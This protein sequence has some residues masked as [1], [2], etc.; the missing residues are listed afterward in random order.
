LEYVEAQP[1]RAV[2]CIPADEGTKVVKVFFI[3]WDEEPEMKDRKG[4]PK[5]G[6][7]PD[8]I[9]LVNPKPRGAMRFRTKL[10]TFDRPRK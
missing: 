4:S 3:S 5:P 1:G 7:L 10:D 9:V 8:F 2:G 6:A